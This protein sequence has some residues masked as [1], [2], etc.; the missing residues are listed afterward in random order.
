M[1]YF[2]KIQDLEEVEN[3]KLKHPLIS[4][5]RYS[6]MKIKN[7]EPAIRSFYR[8]IFIKNFKGTLEIRNLSVNNVDSDGNLYIVLPGQRYLCKSINPLEGYQIDIHQD[9][10]KEYLTEK[11]IDTYNFFSYDVDKFLIL[12]K[13]EKK[14]INFLITQSWSEL[15]N[16]NFSI[17]IILSYISVLLHYFERF[18]NRQFNRHKVM[19]NQIASDFFLYLKTYYLKDIKEPP[20]LSVISDNLNVTANYLGDVIK[21]YTGKSALS[22]IHDFIINEAKFLLKTSNKSISEISYTLGFEY[23]TYFSRLFKKKTNISPSEYRKSVRDFKR[24]KK[25]DT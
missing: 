1:K 23:P 3:L 25:N 5:L 7:I 2:E 8:I 20:S 10:F 14:I 6:D 19:C 18:Y 22:I 21:Y 17:A 16:D 4:I 12:T 24:F 15:N 9:I 11:D 13:K